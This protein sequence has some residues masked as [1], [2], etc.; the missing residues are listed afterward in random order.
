M[1]MESKDVMV[2]IRLDAMIRRKVYYMIRKV[3]Y[4]MIRKVYYVGHQKRQAASKVAIKI[5]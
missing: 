2:M 4:Y 5:N 3:H 1:N